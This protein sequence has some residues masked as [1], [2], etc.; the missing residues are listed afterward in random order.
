MEHNTNMIMKS[1]HE[2]KIS[3]LC[4]V[5]GNPTLFFSSWS[6]SLPLHLIFESVKFIWDYMN[7]G[8]V[9]LVAMVLH[10]EYINGCMRMMRLIVGKGV[11]PVGMG[12]G[13]EIGMGR[14]TCEI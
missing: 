10:V 12:I 14:R 5:F 3:Y 2:R 4:F 6:F 1:L 11:S 8:A 9:L 7:C 13:M